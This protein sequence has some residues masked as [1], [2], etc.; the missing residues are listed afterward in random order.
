LRTTVAL[1]L[2]IVAT[3]FFALTAAGSLSEQSFGL[4][5]VPA[6][7]ACALL[8][9]SAGEAIDA[10]TLTTHE[11][12]RLMV[13]RHTDAMMLPARKMHAGGTMSM[14]L[15][16]PSAHP[17]DSATVRLGILFLLMLLGI[18]V[19]WRGRDTASLGL[20]IFFAMT[21]AF[22]LSHAYAG[23]PD[24]AIIGV[25]FL[26]T[27]LN[28]LG[29]FG[30]YLMVDALAGDTLAPRLRSTARAATIGLLGA[31]CAILI[32]ST[33]GRVFT[34]CPPLLN[35]QIV[36]AC[37]AGVIALCF[38]LLWL[39]IARGDRADRGR[40]RWVFW[41]TVVGYSG[42]LLNFA[43]IASH[44]PMPLHGAFNLTF[45]AIPIGYTY[46]VLRH[47]V[48]DVGFVLNRAI[49]LT[50]LTTAIVA[51]F[52][53]AESLIERL[54]VDHAE[55]MLLQLGFSLGLGMLFNTAHSRLEGWLERTLFRR[56]Y[57]LEQSLRELGERASRFDDEEALLEE[58]A[59]ALTSQ[60]ALVD[61]TIG[62]DP[63]ERSAGEER[64]VLHLLVHGRTYGTIEL[65]EDPRNESLASEELA[66]L[67]SLATQVAAAIAALRAEK[68]ELL[69]KVR[70][71]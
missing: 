9:T 25:L 16:R 24:Q 18:Y 42:P 32:F 26:S 48:I 36:L 21:P 57:A 45:G 55:S 44:Q 1:T 33:Y 30:L 19:L 29:Y 20:G 63:V 3:A 37:Y 62:R 39:G 5:T 52:V 64:I 47:R 53:L 69:L 71:S 46:A 13:P 43:F 8:V 66:L 58:V 59:G 56:R 54:T 23:L 35:V 10:R 60:L 14:V 2:S 28:L 70:T 17:N 68:Y 40:L 49:S 4:T 41:A 61:C 15:F 51:L 31:A 38:L 22:F 67:Q 34:G 7:N 11:R 65:T 6:S 50:I 27:I 12:L